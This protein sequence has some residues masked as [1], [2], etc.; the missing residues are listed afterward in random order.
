MI[1]III[2]HNKGISDN[3]NF[4]IMSI[5]AGVG[6]MLGED[7]QEVGRVAAQKAL[8]QLAS[9]TDLE[10]GLVLVFASSKY[11]QAALLAGV[12]SV[13]A[14][15]LVGSS[16]AGE[17]TADGP[18]EQTAVV[19][20]L[21]GEEVV[22]TVG[23]S[24]QILKDDSHQAGREMARRLQEANRDIS[25]LVIFPDVLV[26]NGADVVRGIQ[27]VFGKTFPI[28]GGASGDDQAFRQTYQYYQ[29]QVLSQSV[30]AVGI[31]GNYRFGVGVRHGWIPIG[32]PMKVT[33][34]DG[35]VVHEIDEKPAVEIYKDYFGE[36]NT[37]KLEGDKAVYTN[38]SVLTYPFGITEQ[39]QS[40]TLIRFAT[41]VSPE[42]SITCAAE[43]PQGSE[44]R[45]MIGNKDKAIEASQIAALQSQEG[46]ESNQS[47]G[48]AIMFN[49][50]AR[51]NL[52]G[53]DANQEIQAV[54][55]VLGNDVPLIGFYTY[56]EQ[57]PV[58][59]VTRDIKQCESSFHNET[60]VIYTLQ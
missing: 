29:D 34:S 60:I 18:S 41:D 1:R 8:D 26:G 13:S 35:A 40:E 52:F 6:R 22:F 28:V 57:A 43:I 42:G 9:K 4:C 23:R 47:I 39:G 48:A 10:V 56:G 32:L 31:S 38:K 44:I 17:I 5:F 46:L 53:E 24:D 36:S 20:M 50:I 12:R 30:V 27:S 3:K 51:H 16:T 14:A 19:M 21:A 37:K 54:R 11:D 55:E 58:D 2:S 59:G 33:R 15:P 49:C 25:S 7:A 45:M